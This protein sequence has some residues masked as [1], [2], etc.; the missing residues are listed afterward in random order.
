MLTCSLILFIFCS[1]WLLLIKECFI[2]NAGLLTHF[3]YFLFCLIAF[4]KRMLYTECWP[5]H[6]FERFCYISL[7]FSPADYLNIEALVQCLNS[8]VM[9]SPQTQQEALLVMT[10]I[11]PLYPVRFKIQN[12]S[13][14]IW[15]SGVI[16]DSCLPSFFR[17]FFHIPVFLQEHLLHNI[18]S[19]FTF[20]GTSL[21]QKDDSYTFQIITKTVD[22]VID[23]ILQVGNKIQIKYLN[24]SMQ[25][26]VGI[27]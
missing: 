15:N 22:V 13:L 7:F 17:F 6:S 11:A 2:Q 24:F 18:V 23:S 14:E 12:P 21:L 25:Q 19:I 3:I 16:F 5:A 26:F 1:V 27:L 9:V 10:A 8:S 4:D 20:M